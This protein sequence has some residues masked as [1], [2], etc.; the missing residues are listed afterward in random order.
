[1]EQGTHRRSPRSVRRLVLL[2][3]LC[4]A[5]TVSPERNGDK[6]PATTCWPVPRPAVAD[7][8]CR[9]HTFL[10]LVCDPCGARRPVTRIR[11]VAVV[12]DLVLEN[13]SR[14]STLMPTEKR[15]APLAR[16]LRQTLRTTARRPTARW[17]RRVSQVL[18]FAQ[19]LWQSVGGST[20]LHQADRSAHRR[21]SLRRSRPRCGRR[22]R[23][24][25]SHGGLVWWHIGYRGASFSLLLPPRATRLQLEMEVSAELLSCCRRRRV[26]PIS[27]PSL[28][29]ALAAIVSLPW[30]S[31]RRRPEATITYHPA[32][33]VNHHIVHMC[34]V[35]ASGH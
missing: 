10:C 26:T 8:R 30:L 6:C 1:M 20:R 3:P 27:R 28:P 34:W 7:A 32:Q 23:H 31:G 9:A 11:G 4:R 12:C 21:K 25:V 2:F 15:P 29:H 16:A 14:A 18:V 35:A 5:Q 24:A 17:P 22:L 19:S 13:L 33:T